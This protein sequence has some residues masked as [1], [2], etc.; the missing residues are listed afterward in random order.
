MTLVDAD[1]L[2]T[3]QALADYRDVAFDEND[4]HAVTILK[5]VSAFVR[6]KTSQTISLVE[7]DTQELRGTWDQDLWLPQRPVLDVVSLTERYCG[8]TEFVAYTEFEWNRRGNLWRAGGWGGPGHTVRV[9]YDHGYDVIP[10]DIVGIVLSIAA[11]RYGASSND[12]LASETI[13]SYSYTNATAADG[14]PIGLT[15]EESDVIE[16]YKPKDG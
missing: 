5:T 4:F 15:A 9:T 16:A 3:P 7:T 13:G 14:T 10:P 12:L 1:L 2:A 11:R 6:R 8:S